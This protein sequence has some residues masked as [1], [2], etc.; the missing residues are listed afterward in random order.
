MWSWSEHSSDCRIHI[1]LHVGHE[2]VCV[3]AAVWKR[4]N[5]KKQQTEKKT[6]SRSRF[7]GGY[8]VSVRWWVINGCFF[9]A[10]LMAASTFT[11]R[12]TTASFTVASTLYSSE[13]MF[14]TFTVRER[15]KVFHFLY[16]GVRLKTQSSQRYSNWSRCNS[17]GY[18][19][20]CTAQARA[21]NVDPRFSVI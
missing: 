3:K 16:D 15:D 5:K 7:C 1:I 8:G 19:Q 6:L 18:N 17:W 11:A 9:D 2:T 4:Q 13:K 10:V 20:P 12:K 21:V 14:L